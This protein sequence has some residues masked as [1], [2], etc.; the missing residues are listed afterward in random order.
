CPCV[1]LG[2]ARTRAAV[3]PAAGAG[4]EQSGLAGPR[5]GVDRCHRPDHHRG[6]PAARPGRDHV[7]RGVWRDP[8]EAAVGAVVS[9]S[10]MSGPYALVR[11]GDSAIVVEFEGGMDPR[12]NARAVAVAET[13]V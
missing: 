10:P 5:G 8:R 4:C 11:A 2:P 13:L 1:S 6:T 7:Q 9:S 12:V 3:G